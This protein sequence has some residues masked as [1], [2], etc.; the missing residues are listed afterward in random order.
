M[1]S[2]EDVTMKT[3]T[4]PENFDGQ[5]FL[6]KFSLLFVDFYTDDSLLYYDE[7]KTGKILTDD[8]IADCVV[9]VDRLQRIKDRENTSKIN[10]KNV[11]GY[12]T[13]SENEA[14]AWLDT[15]I[16]DQ[17]IDAIGNLADAKILLKDISKAIRGIT[18][19]EIAIR[20]HLWPDLPED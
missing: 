1:G 14:L 10:A 8:D 4:L 9:D 5:L 17:K 19:I 13:W 16:S 20:N 12:A 6:E 11:P 15:H 2:C 3:I 18:R 7:N